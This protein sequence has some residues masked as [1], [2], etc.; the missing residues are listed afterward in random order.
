MEK[1]QKN[2][3][4]KD[5]PCLNLER[6]LFCGQAFRWI[7]K[8]DG[9]F[10]AVVKDKIIDVKQNG[11]EIVFENTSDEE[12]KKLIESYFDLKR[13][14]KKICNVLSADKSFKTAFDEYEGIRI[15]KQDSWEALCSFIISQNN[16][17]PRISGIIDRFCKAFGE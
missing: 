12:T 2:M 1:I 15:L 5:F 14:Y 8:D 16:N 7:R 9:S 3:V 17:I 4:L 11:S 13:D 6:T 10:H